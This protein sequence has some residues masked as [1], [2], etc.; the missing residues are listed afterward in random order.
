MFATVSKKTTAA[1]LAS[2][3]R[4]ASGR[5]IGRLTARPFMTNG[6]KSFSYSFKRVET[7]EPVLPCGGL[8]EPASYD[9]WHIEPE[10]TREP[11]PLS[12]DELEAFRR[13]YTEQECLS[14][15]YPVAY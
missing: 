15:S 2:L 3:S 5:V 10:E 12:D 7:V 6:V 8:D 1:Q 4:S 13:V 9:P 11:I 14:N